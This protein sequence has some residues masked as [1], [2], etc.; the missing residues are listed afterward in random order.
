[1]MNN[2][3]ANSEFM[4]CLRVKDQA[5]FPKEI[6]N[7]FHQKEPVQS[8]NTT[9]VQPNLHSEQS[10]LSQIPVSCVVSVVVSI[11]IF[12]LGFII[13]DWL[14]KRRKRGQLE[15]YKYVATE[16]AEK[17]LKVAENYRKNLECFADEVKNNET[18]QQLS[19][20]VIIIPVDL[21][22]GLSLENYISTFVFNI[23]NKNEEDNRKRLTDFMNQLVYLEKVQNVITKE[24]KRYSEANEKILDEWNDASVKLKRILALYRGTNRGILR[25]RK[26]F[27][28]V[29]TEDIKPLNWKRTF[30]EPSLELIAEM[31][32]NETEIQQIY[33]LLDSLRNTSLKFENSRNISFVFSDYAQSM[34]DCIKNV[35]GC[36]QFFSEQELKSAWWI[37]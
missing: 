13:N 15:Q 37:A 16:W 27:I 33:I 1:M 6:I 18:F 36:I 17:V 7:L 3:V 4:Y 10:I 28:S 21:V 26:S 22:T 12:V 9:S 31:E 24:Y 32:I 23:K 2:E 30:I 5:E 29:V 34:G 19:F 8:F 25:I 35:N 20:E 11:I 14:L